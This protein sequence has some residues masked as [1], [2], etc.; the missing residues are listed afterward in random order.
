MLELAEWRLHRYQDERAAK[1]VIQFL[2]NAERVEEAAVYLRYVKDESWKKREIQTVTTRMLAQYGINS[3]SNKDFT[4]ME[5]FE[6]EAIVRAELDQGVIHTLKIE[7]STPKGGIKRKMKVLHNLL[8]ATLNLHHPLL[9]EL[10]AEHGLFPH[11]SIHLA[12][13]LN[14]AFSPLWR[15]S[16]C[17]E[18]T[19]VR[20]VGTIGK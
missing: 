14:A 7:L 17:D 12:K 5:S 18:G 1:S 4:E 19:R 9:Y 2:R 16:V 20:S 15:S 11:D 3:S 10:Y 6:V 8:K 13:R